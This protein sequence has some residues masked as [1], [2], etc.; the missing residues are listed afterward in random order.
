MVIS[1]EI[2]SALPG[3]ASS[4]RALVLNYAGQVGT[5]LEAP[6]L[7]ANP[8]QTRAQLVIYPAGRTC[9]ASHIIAS[10]AIFRFVLHTRQAMQLG[11]FPGVRTIRLRRKKRQ[12]YVPFVNWTMMASRLH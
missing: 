4:G 3:I 12:I 7:E 8:F 5:F 1:V 10:Q 2:Q 6:D 11:W 9:N